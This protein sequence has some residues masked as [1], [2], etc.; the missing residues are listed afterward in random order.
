M[1]RP[2]RISA[3][4][5]TKLT[6]AAVDVEGEILLGDLVVFAVVADRLDGGVDAV[7]DGG[8]LLA[9]AGADARSEDFEIFGDDAL[10]VAAGLALVGLQ[11]GVER[12]GIGLRGV[13]AAGGEILVRLVLGLVFL[14]LGGL[15]EVLLRVGGM[16][17]STPARR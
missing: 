4:P 13:D 8:V 11:E 5:R 7:L 6:S 15:G 10:E 1:H 9:Q 17:R 2:R 3:R 12:D 16:R 14:D